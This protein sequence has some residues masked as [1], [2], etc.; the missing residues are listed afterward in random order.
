MIV[1]DEPRQAAMSPPAAEALIREARRRQHR[2]W[3][4]M[5]VAV[6]TVGVASG[7]WFTSKGGAAGTPSSSLAKTVP[8]PVPRGLGTLRGAVRLDFQADVWSSGADS[9]VGVI[10]QSSA[11]G[12]KNESSP[13]PASASR[14]SGSRC[15]AVGTALAVTWN[16]KTLAIDAVPARVKGVSR[17]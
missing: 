14:A 10:Q 11:E 6:L 2:R 8:S 16:G 13:L 9:C 5:G 3:L 17:S 4:L 15:V 12:W 7:L 1:L